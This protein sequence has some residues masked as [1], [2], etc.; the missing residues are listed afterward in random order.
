MLFVN[1]IRNSIASRANAA[2]SRLLRLKY[3]SCAVLLY[4]RVA[5]LDTDPQLLAVSP[6]NFDLHLGILKREFHLLT[7]E[8]FKEHL[9]TGKKFPEKSV[10]LTFDDGY[11]DNH[12]H[13]VPLLEAHKAEAL[14]YI[15]T[16]N[17][18][19]DHEFWW[20]ELERLMLCGDKFPPAF[21]VEIK[22]KNFSCSDS[23]NSRKAMY[24]ELLPV[25]R[26]MD[27][28]S[29]QKIFTEVKAML[30][31]SLPRESHRSVTEPELKEMSNSP[32]VTIGAH[33]VNHCSLNWVKIDEQ[34]L[35]IQRSIKTIEKIAEK[36]VSD[37]SYPFGT[38]NDFSK[39]T[40]DICKKAGMKFVSANI[41]GCVHS[42]SNPYSF[43]RFLVRDWDENEFRK[44]VNSFFQK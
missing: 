13:A 7:V 4:H 10:F 27:F 22:G 42:K 37:F 15:C 34:I 12:Q 32:S 30:P 21:L 33:T 18:G 19:T 3:G 17:I 6:E 38:G 40:I 9:R 44:Q 31:A 28:I 1:R 23:F 24:N 11:A 16:G 26:R 20:D 14:F 35:E 39:D 8:G 36:K 29:R 25:L 2:A 5:R 43:P 41:P